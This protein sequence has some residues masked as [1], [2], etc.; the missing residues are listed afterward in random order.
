M[1]NNNIIEKS[2]IF[3]ISKSILKIKEKKWYQN[4][5]TGTNNYNHKKIKKKTNNNNKNEIFKKKKYNFL[6]LRIIIK[7]THLKIKKIINRVISIK[8]AIII[9]KKTIMIKS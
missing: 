3:K 1:V 6:K 4:V 2:I 7:K 9:M 5:D 8:L